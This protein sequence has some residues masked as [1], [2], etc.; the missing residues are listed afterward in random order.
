[1]CRGSRGSS[2]PPQAST[3][4]KNDPVSAARRGGRAEADRGTARRAPP[5]DR[6]P[7]QATE[8]RYPEIIG[9]LSVAL[10]ETFKPCI[11]MSRTRGPAA[12]AV[13]P[14]CLSPIRTD[15]PGRGREAETGE[16]HA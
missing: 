10:A 9:G 16:D 2:A 13:A 14:R 5:L 12:V 1:M 11:R 6:T 15:M 8:E 3:L 7:T 4:D